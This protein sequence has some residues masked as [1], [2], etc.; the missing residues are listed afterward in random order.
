MKKIISILLITAVLCGLSVYA[1]ENIA[2]TNCVQNIENKTI[3]VTLSVPEGASRLTLILT[4]RPV[5][6]F[7]VMNNAAGSIISFMQY[8]Y[9]PQMPVSIGYLP[10]EPETTNTVYV[11][12]NC[13]D[14]YMA[15]SSVTLKSQNDYIVDTFKN[16]T[17]WNSYPGLVS[18]YNQAFGMF[19]LA[20]EQAAALATFSDTE[21]ADVYKAMYLAKN[22]FSLVSDVEA[23][24]TSAINSVLAAKQQGTQNP[25][26]GGGGGGGGGGGMLI[27]KPSEEQPTDAKP[28]VKPG[29]SA[30][31]S[32]LN[33]E[34]WAKEAIEYLYKNG[35]VNGVEENK[36]APSRILKREEFITMLIRG[37]KLE[38]L[39][40]GIDFADV[41]ADSYFAQYV[42]IAVSRGIVK[43]IDE[44]SFGAGLDLKRQDLAV[45]LYRAFFDGVQPEGDAQPLDM[46]EIADYAQTAVKVLME[47]GIVNGMGD[48]RFAPNDNSN[49]AQAAQLIYN[50]KLKGII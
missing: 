20:A 40:E 2:I 41:P 13:G 45:M 18:T 22:N 14:A 39:S 47:K 11:Y 6:N 37:T 35:I 42:K 4:R 25:G 7:S 21:T 29:Q 46:E 50:L 5:N 44:S 1:A 10:N 36:F 19:D 12:A 48:G 27:P 15:S 33:D 24:Y 8:D 34:P 43:G 17:A 9:V 38:I 30:V 32:D 16:A 3:D 23:A 49:R 28:V 31:F 26:S